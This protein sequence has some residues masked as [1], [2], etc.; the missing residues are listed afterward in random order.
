M[1]NKS[2]FYIFFL[3]FI[4]ISISSPLC[5]EGQKFCKRCN[6]V[7]KLCN[8]CTHDILIPD[9]FGGCEGQ[10]KC[11]IG[12]NYCSECSSDNKLCKTCEN[13]FYPDENGGCS[14][15]NNCEISHQGHCLKCSEDF[16]LVGTEVKMCK[17][18]DS[19]ELINCLE[20]D[21]NTG[22]CKSCQEGYYLNSGDSKCGKTQYC[23]ESSYGVCTKCSMSYYLD[24]STQECK[25]KDSNWLYCQQTVDGKN[26]DICDE[27]AYFDDEG[28]CVAVNN[29][30]KGAPYA[31]CEKCKE[32]YYLAKYGNCCSQE[33]NCYFGDKD[34]GICNQCIDFYYIDFNDGKC[35]PNN[36][37]N[38]FKY[39]RKADKECYECV[40][41]TY[42]GEDKK[43]S[44]SKNCSES[45][46]GT[47]LYCINGFHLG[48]DN[49]CN[50]I[51]K[52]IKSNYFNSCEE[53][54]K[55]YYFNISSNLCEEENE[56]FINCRKT[57]SDGIFCD[58][59][60]QDFYLNYPD[61]KCYSNLEN[62][63]FY[64]C[65]LT[66]GEVCHSCVQDYYLGYIDKK[67]TKIQGCEISENENKC[68][69]CDSESYCLNAHNGNCI[70]NE[71][72][73][74]E[75]DKFFYRCNYTDEEG[76]KCEQCID[77]Y[78][79]NNKG[80]CV[81]DEFCEEFDQDKNCK[82]CIKDNDEE[83]IF[84]CL[85]QDFECTLTYVKGC[86]LCN[87]VTNFDYCSK[88]KEDYT[89]DDGQC[90]KN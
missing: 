47:C 38:D 59:C 65:S 75:K 21:I 39:C 17:S 67:C 41:G 22:L 87:D 44:T 33:P 78:R 62:N 40:S 70:N 31:K 48:T 14:F 32:N 34:L 43:C 28:K 72:I 84:Y 37:D 58:S 45:K 54:E 2:L 77:N 8:K 80:F 90:I 79:L 7:T 60:K 86:E 26:C 15:I 46:Y 30:A 71:F 61:H 57:D 52:C 1:S 55:G 73:E 25:M 35:K 16:L 24:K 83:S 18:F 12:K 63:E 56:G 27:D 88:C 23:H 13:N 53:C 9:K 64:K 20:I 82:K 68:L 74:E 89:L 3:T 19:D 49:I 81:F 85:N 76:T 5:E 69:Q 42:L 29:C 36:E 51:D 6:P 50:N 4:E 10:K 11:S 66:Y